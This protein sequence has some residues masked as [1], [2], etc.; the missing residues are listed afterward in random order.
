LEHVVSQNP[1][2]RETFEAIQGAYERLLPVVESGQEFTVLGDGDLGSLAETSTSCNFAEGFTGGKS[3]M[4]SLQLLIKTQI[5]IYRRFEVEMG[6][7]KYPAYQLLF[8]CLKLSTY[9]A[10]AREKG[11]AT[12]MFSSTL[13]SRKRAM[14][15]RDTVE[16][17]FRTC[18]A[19]P[20]NAE[21]LISEKGVHVLEAILDF[22]LHAASL[23]HNRPTAILDVA[24][25]ELVYDILSNV[26]HIF[27][28]IAFYESGRAAIESLPD[29][30]R[31]CINWR[32]CLDGKYL[33]P[34]SKETIDVTLK[35]FSV[36]GVSNMSRST[37]LQNALVGAGILW[38]IGRF[39]L[40]FDPTLD[41][42]SIS[43]ENL[44]DDI[45]VSQASKNV[46][47]RLAVRALGML[48]GFMQDPK[49][50]APPNSHVQ[51]ALKTLL[52]SPIALLLRN[53]RTG[54][55]LR[56]LNTNVETPSRIWNVEM[57]NEL[58]KVISSMEQGRPESSVQSLVEEL[59]GLSGFAYSTLTNEMQIGGI[60]VRLFNKLGAE[61]GGL[62]HID[63]P[64]VFAIQLAAY[65]A[66]CV[67]DS[68]D[69]ADNFLA[70]TVPDHDDTADPETVAINDQRFIMALSAMSILFRSNGLVDEVLFDTSTAV[71]SLLLSLLELP[72]DSEVRFPLND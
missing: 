25:E 64:S 26:V 45:G 2:G 33:V 69:L 23:M 12:E 55:I 52:T 43:R 65:V 10:G 38:P 57:R 1:S 70:L 59:G 24:P 5:L 27:A 7:Y 40:G 35:R 14:F 63:D 50:A 53:K 68:N 66:R 21:E 31:F 44:E 42:A 48:S 16:L 18:L 17:I 46:Q 9:S 67:N 28:G 22:Y 15:V 30:P 58:L 41:E 13:M 11:D 56:T 8:S 72:L 60:Y 39:V 47:A 37:I 20:L 32:R 3:Q 62:R 6:K 71:S 61:K 51:A 34:K 4:E 54:E 36:E 29:L 49:L 19:S